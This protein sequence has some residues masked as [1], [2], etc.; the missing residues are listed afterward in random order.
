M[1]IF[2]THCFNTADLSM[3][4][5]I[6]VFK[7]SASLS[8]ALTYL[9]SLN[10]NS[11]F[12]KNQPIDIE[13]HIYLHQIW[14]YDVL[15]SFFF[16]NFFLNWSIIPLLCCISFCCISMWISYMYTYIPSLLGV[17][18]TLHPTPL[19]NHRFSL[20]LIFLKENLS[21]IYAS[22]YTYLLKYKPLPFILHC[23]F[24]FVFFF[25]GV[26]TL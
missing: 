7:F 19:G 18:L 11:Y 21:S 12:K 4:L 24:C 17:S 10:S 13:T 8:V 15:I 3:N 16:L 14:E 25:F 20:L 6:Y 26:F 9:F 2:I 22:I 1:H 5:C 23:I